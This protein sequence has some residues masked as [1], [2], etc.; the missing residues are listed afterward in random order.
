MT[1][2]ITMFI[3]IKKILSSLLVT[4]TI[5]KLKG[6]FSVL[7]EGKMLNWG[8]INDNLKR[9]SNSDESKRLGV[10]YECNRGK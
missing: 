6:I 1:L 9:E 7:N 8:E 10:W 2:C 3:T 5:N 4:G